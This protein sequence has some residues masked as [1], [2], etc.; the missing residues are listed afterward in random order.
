MAAA[1]VAGLPPGLLFAPEDEVAVEHY[2]LPRL[3]GWQLP[4]DGLILDDDPLS[5]PP[6][7]LLERNGRGEEAFFFAEGQ[8]RCGK[9]TR[10]KRTCAGGG[11]WE[12]QKTCAEGDKLRVPGGGGGREAA[13][14]K[15]A[16]N[17]HCGG[18]GRKGS[19]GWV[20]HEYAIT[21]PE[22]L[23]RSPLRLYHIRLSSYGRKQSGA[24]EVPR[25]LGLPPGFLFAPEDGDV[26]ACY[27]LP[28]VLG[29]PLPLDGLILDDDPRSA[30]PW[31]LLE[32]NGRR[33]DAFFFALGQVKSSKG[34]RQKR[35]CVGGGFWNGERTCVDGEKLL[36]PGLAG[37]EVMEWRKRALSFQHAG[38]KGSTGWVMHEYA[39]TAPDH[40]AESQL[41]L[42]RIRFSGHG[43]KRKRAEADPSA[44]ESAAPTAARRRVAEE[45]DTLLGMLMPSSDPICSSVVLADQADGNGVNGAELHAAPV[46]V[47][48]GQDLTSGMDTSWDGFLENFDIDELLRSIGDLPSPSPGV[49]PAVTG[50]GAYLDADAEV[51]SFFTQTAAAAAPPYAG[52]GAG[53]VAPSA[54][55]MHHGCTDPADSFF[56]PGPNQSYA[57]C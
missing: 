29:Q 33:E 41:R 39:I 49:L 32:R 28:R 18:A 56:F 52:F 26:V 9:G 31:E 17:F 24:M 54:P 1:C 2:L 15:K 38:D 55:G 43:K 51:S 44:D 50:L 35:T 22:D 23:A 3:L 36:I 13:W 45:D 27:L 47:S 46:T 21:A 40:L 7:E 8:A 12:G 10:Q 19:T 25:A 14:R 34:S 37:S 11:W 5:A 16:L 6:R 20:M 57:A 48:A 42:F 4:V 30:P 53:L